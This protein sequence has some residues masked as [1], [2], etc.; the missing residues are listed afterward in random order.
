MIK[1][2]LYKIMFKFRVFLINFVPIHRWRKVLR[3]FICE[4]GIRH[5]VNFLFYECLQY[6][7][8]SQ[9][10]NSFDDVLSIVAIAKDEVPYMMEWLEY[11]ILRGGQRSSFIYTIT[12]ALII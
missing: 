8:S 3:F 7:K 1:M 6:D 4:L 11:H 2:C 10:K 5:F 9:D 12:G